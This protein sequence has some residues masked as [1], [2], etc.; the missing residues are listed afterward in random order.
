MKELDVEG[1]QF[2]L[3]LGALSFLEIQEGWLKEENLGWTKVDDGVI[4]VSWHCEIRTVEQ[5]LFTLV[6]KTLPGIDPMN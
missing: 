2:A 1:F 4:L 3:D 5:E 6:L